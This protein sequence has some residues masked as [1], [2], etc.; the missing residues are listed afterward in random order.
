MPKISTYPALD[1]VSG[2]TK[3]LVVH[4]ADGVTNTYTT[5]VTVIFASNAAPKL[6]NHR[7]DTPSNSTATTCSPGEMWTD[8]TYVYIGTANNVCRRASFS[9]F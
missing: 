6:L 1:S 5:N 3:L 4:T 9:T 2:N 8:G 7:S